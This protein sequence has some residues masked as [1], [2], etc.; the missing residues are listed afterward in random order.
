[1]TTDARQKFLKAEEEANRVLEALRAL[2]QEM[3][4]YKSHNEIIETASDQLS[5]SSRGLDQFV[6]G[7]EQQ[8]EEVKSWRP[9]IHDQLARQ[10]ADLVGVR[11][12]LKFLLG[13]T[14][15]AWVGLAALVAFL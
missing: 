3:E 8:L 11:A 1:M 14:V 12:Q 2:N 6:K 4:T 15:V 13:V 5:L 7:L 10:Q 9:K